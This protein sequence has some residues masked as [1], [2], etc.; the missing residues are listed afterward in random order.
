MSD[1]ENEMLVLLVPSKLML[2]FPTS[3]KHGSHSGDR[4]P[5]KIVAQALTSPCSAFLQSPCLISVE[6]PHE[7]LCTSWVPWRS[8][9]SAHY[10]WPRFSS[11]SSVRTGFKYR[12]IFRNLLAICH[13]QIKWPESYLWLTSSLLSTPP[14]AHWDDVSLSCPLLYISPWPFSP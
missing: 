14:T 7:G 3:F 6:N 2:D 12:I 1:T 9:W 5:G 10:E 8:L 4:E 13:K 11:A